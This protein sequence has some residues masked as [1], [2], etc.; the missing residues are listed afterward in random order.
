MGG[1]LPGSSSLLGTPQDPEWH[2]EGDVLTHTCHCLDALV[3]LPGWQAAEAEFED[4][5]A[6]W[7][8]WRHDFAKPQTTHEAIKDDRRAVSSRPSR[9][10]GGPLAKR[11]LERNQ[12]AARGAERVIPLVTNH[13]AHLQTITDPFRAPAG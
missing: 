5:L 12:R 9:S 1:T 8:C 6:R 11:F 13:L 4:H 3:K 10:G 7:R 2:P